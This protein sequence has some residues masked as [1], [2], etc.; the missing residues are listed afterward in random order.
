MK[1]TAMI[2]TLCFY[3]G[4]CDGMY[5]TYVHKSD[6]LISLNPAIEFKIIIIIQAVASVINGL[7]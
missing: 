6:H 3:R 7:L 4:N 2:K 5:T 1:D